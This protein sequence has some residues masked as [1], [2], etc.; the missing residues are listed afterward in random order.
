[1]VTY[2]RPPRQD[3]DLAASI[4]A[5][6]AGTT[7]QLS[8]DFDSIPSQSFDEVLAEAE[9]AVAGVTAWSD[10]PGPSVQMA[11][12]PPDE[13]TTSGARPEEPAP[14]GPAA[15]P[16]P[17]PEYLETTQPTAPD[18]TSGD[19]AAGSGDRAPGSG[20][21]AAEATGPDDPVAGPD[22]AVAPAPRGR[23]ARPKGPAVPRSARRTTA[24]APPSA[25]RSAGPAPAPQPIP[26]LFERLRSL[27]VPEDHLPDPG[28]LTLDAV[29]RSMDG[30][31]EAPDLPTAP[32]SVIAVVGTAAAVART[33][34][35]LTGAAP[36]RH[37]LRPDPARRVWAPEDPTAPDGTL[38]DVLQLGDPLEVA[39]RVARRRLDGRPSLVTV[40]VTPGHPVRSHDRTVIASV[41]PDYV[42]GA[43]DASVKRADAA[44]W[45]DDLGVLDA[46]AL[47]GLDDT[48]SPAELVGVL[49]VAFVDG[50]P[51]TPVNWTLNLLHRAAEGGG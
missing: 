31:P 4:A 3:D 37:G 1:V 43:I 36:F 23:R 48:V 24:P 18:G 22:G 45:R 51:G 33:T 35:L 39:G 15:D 14:P 50:V 13:G 25:P 10:R 29:A 12:A 17:S 40:E 47:W 9:A 21:R 27:G 44:R 32:G 26:D 8:L 34:R 46:L 7:D 19:R 30:L 11:V 6:A 5:L 38:D 16:D 42:L 41:Q 49:P 2:E 28:R 20:D